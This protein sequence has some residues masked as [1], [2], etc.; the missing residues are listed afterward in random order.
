MFTKPVGT[1]G[2]R[3]TP[4]LLPGNLLVNLDASVSGKMFTTAAGS[5]ES[6]DGGAIA[7]WESVSPATLGRMNTSD[8]GTSG[9]TARLE[10]G[11]L[12]AECLGGSLALSVALTKTWTAQTVYCLHRV[13]TAASNSFFTMGAAQT[14]PWY[15]IRNAAGVQMRAQ[16]YT[17][18]QFAAYSP[19]MAAKWAIVAFVFDGATGKCFAYY[20][21]A[22]KTLTPGGEAGP[23][24]VDGTLISLGRG[25]SS[26]PCDMRFA[27]LRV[28]DSAH[29]VGN[30]RALSAYWRSQFSTL[31][32]PSE[33]WVLFTGS[34]HMMDGSVGVNGQ[35][36]AQKCLAGSSE[37][38]TSYNMAFS[39]STTVQNT[40]R[41][42]NEAAYIGRW[43]T[44]PMVLAHHCGGNDISAGGMSAAQVYS[45]LKAHIQAWKVIYPSAKYVVGTY[46]P[47]TGVDNSV[48][49][50]ANAL[51]V[52][53]ADGAFDGVADMASDPD[54][55][56]D[57]DNADLTYYRPDGTHKTDAGTTRE[58]SYWI[59]VIDAQFV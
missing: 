52:A 44:G 49:N 42:A 58:A 14:F 55:G 28:Y 31:F 36:L 48:R 10:G 7:G 1:Y 53:D 47:Q 12:V 13:T 38:A 59:P 54:M 11:M 20:D 24:S 39:G 29:S 16:P 45:N 50:A 21:D 40:A 30:F 9:F 41:I 25:P 23:A 3:F 57:G 8:S 33:P 17:T 26:N 4:D 6:A 19:V 37:Y 56:G 2:Y 34:S 51:I 18:N 22:D 27:A 35:G 43:R 46:M 32:T 5:T 15:G